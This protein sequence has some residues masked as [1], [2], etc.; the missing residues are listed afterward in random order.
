MNLP[1]VRAGMAILADHIQR[2]NAAIRQVQIRPGPGYRLQQTGGGTTLVIDRGTIGGG[3]ATVVCP[4]FE[5]TDASE[6]AALKVKVAQSQIAGR[7]PDGMGL[8][9]PPFVLSIYASSYIYAKVTY[10]TTALTI[11][12]ES[13]AITISASETIQANTAEDVYI[14]L[15]T[16]VVGGDP[17]AITEINNVCA[18]PVPSPCDLEWSE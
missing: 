4:Y 7:W 3:K 5:C 2:L 16:V 17:A 8:D 18:Q 15:A 12:P 13:D 9:F 14:L 1:D 11:L 10:D 6:G